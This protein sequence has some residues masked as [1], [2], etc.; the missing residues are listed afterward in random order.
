[1]TPPAEGQVDDLAWAGDGVEGLQS[2]QYH[3]SLLLDVAS[4]TQR[5]P[6]GPFQK[7]AAW[8][9]HF[10]GV[11]THD[12]YPDSGDAGFLNLSLDQPHGLI[13]DASGRGQQNDVD[14][15][16]SQAQGNLFCT[17][18]DKLRNVPAVDMPHKG[19]TLSG[20]GTN[21]PLIGELL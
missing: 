21:N 16:C 7:N 17:L 2:F 10:L 12:R 14:V 1:M 8:R 3:G 13:T 4:F 9:L 15:I 18:F 5:V 11:F 6:E 19:K 20:Q